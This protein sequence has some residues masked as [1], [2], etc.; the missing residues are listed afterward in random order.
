MPTSTAARLNTSVGRPFA[1]QQLRG[2]SVWADWL[3]EI[4]MKLVA[5]YLL[6]LVSFSAVA[7]EVGPPPPRPT[8]YNHV[9]SH[10]DPSVATEQEARDAFASEFTVVDIPGSSKYEPP[11]LILGDLYFDAAGLPSGQVFVLCIVTLEGRVSAPHV[12]RSSG[13]RL[14]KIVLKLLNAWRFQ[15]ATQ[16]G[17]SISI[18]A[19]F[20]FAYTAPPTMQPGQA[21]ERSEL[22]R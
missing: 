5:R 9:I 20:P 17:V 1:C 22:S 21:L 13:T 16:N 7:Q 4:R 11:K 12:V 8:V 19:G 6:A 15:P 3:I 14:E 2:R 18:I 10:E